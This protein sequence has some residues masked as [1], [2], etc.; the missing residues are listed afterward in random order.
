MLGSI[1]IA[2]VVFFQNLLL[3]SNQDLYST[4]STIPQLVFYVHGVRYI[5]LA[6]VPC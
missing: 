4:I 2:Q 6:V 1:L 5:R 3:L